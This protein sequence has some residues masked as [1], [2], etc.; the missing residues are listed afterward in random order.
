MLRSITF[1][2]LALVTP[3]QERH[4]VVTGQSDSVAIS[5]PVVFVGDVDRDG[6]QDKIGRAHV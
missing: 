4:W 6:Y 1:L 5:T 2:V 3:A